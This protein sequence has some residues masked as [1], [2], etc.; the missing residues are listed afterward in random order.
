MHKINISNHDGSKIYN[1][2]VLD[3]EINGN[4]RTI[5]PVRSEYNMTPAIKVKDQIIPGININSDVLPT[6]F[7]FTALDTF[8]QNGIKLFYLDGQEYHNDL[9][10][11]LNA[12]LYLDKADNC[13]LLDKAFENP[14]PAVIIDCEDV[15]DAVKKMA[16][17]AY[18]SQVPSKSDWNGYASAQDP[19]LGVVKEF[20]S[21]LQ[22]SGTAAQGYFGFSVDVPAL[23]QK[24]IFGGEGVQATRSK[25]DA[26]LLFKKVNFVL[27][28]RRARQ[29]RIVNAVNSC[30]TSYGYDLVC[31]ALGRVNADDKY[32]IDME[33]C[34]NRTNCIIQKLT[35]I[36]TLIKVE[37]NAV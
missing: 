22:M 33:A 4:V 32:Q 9:D 16:T 15:S 3:I 7:C 11:T 23:K 12:Y 27:G 17:S 21:M 25:E 30:I 8:I 26:L 6:V 36:I 28:S 10:T 14:L 35:E 20:A 18:L 34:E 2:P 19:I 24:A 31:E 13:L 37:R 29:T 5:I 1:V